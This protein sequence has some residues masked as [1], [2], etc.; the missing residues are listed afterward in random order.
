VARAIVAQT[1]ARSDDLIV[2][3]GAG[4]GEIGMPLAR[5]PQRYVGLDASPTMLR[6][7]R[8]KALDAAPSLILADCDETWPLR[9]RVAGVVVASRIIHL[10]DPDHATREILRVCRPGGR[11][12]LGRVVRERDGIKER[13]RRRRHDL[14]EVAGVATRQGEERTRRVIERCLAAGGESAGRWVV[15]EWSGEASPAGI[16]DGWASQSRMGSSAVTPATGAAILDQLRDWART[17]F[18]DLERPE[19]FR[20]RY[21]IDIVHLP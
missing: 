6:L 12:V 9:D 11:L 14:L 20:E 2:E 13:L 5:L 4:T 18:G 8:A 19:P 21:A 7:F 3:L 15:A 16:I 17:E 1:G 10:L